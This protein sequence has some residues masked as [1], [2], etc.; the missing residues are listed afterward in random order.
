MGSYHWK[1][2]FPSMR[3]IA[4]AITTNRPWHQRGLNK[5]SYSCAPGR[6]SYVKKQ[7]SLFL[8]SVGDFVECCG[9]A[10]TRCLPLS[11]LGCPS[12][13]ILPGVPVSKRHVRKYQRIAFGGRREMRTDDGLTPFILRSLTIT[14]V[15]SLLV[16]LKSTIRRNRVK[17][18]IARERGRETVRAVKGGRYPFE[19]VRTWIGYFMKRCEIAVEGAQECAQISSPSVSRADTYLLRYPRCHLPHNSPEPRARCTRRRYYDRQSPP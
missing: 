6:C 18:C 10:N 8:Y 16:G 3:P 9:Q 11:P 4:T 15:L 1:P 19:V 14:C 17:R 2:S 5:M 7:F 12:P 13:I